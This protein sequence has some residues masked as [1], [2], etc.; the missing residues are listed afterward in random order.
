MNRKISCSKA[1]LTLGL[2]SIGGGK[3]ADVIRVV[4]KA[5]AK[6]A[7]E[8]CQ[9]L[10]GETLSDERLL[11]KVRGICFPTG[12][13]GISATDVAEFLSSVIGM[14]ITRQAA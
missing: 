7:A 4:G 6:L 13:A 10:N 9:S 14:L 12:A 8:L 3:Y 11:A 2:R 5:P 1:N